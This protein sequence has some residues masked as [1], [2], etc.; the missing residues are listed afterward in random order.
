MFA[1]Q[2]RRA[3]DPVAA[4]N[5]PRLNSVNKVDEIVAAGEDARSGKTDPKAFRD[6]MKKIFWRRSEATPIRLAALKEIAADDEHT[7]DTI[8]MLG[9]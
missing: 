2:V 5:N 3:H 7:A 4:L 6:S 9:S 8:T 1:A